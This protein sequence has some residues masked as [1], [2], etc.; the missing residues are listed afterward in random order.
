MRNIINKTEIVKIYTCESIICNC[1]GKEFKPED[2]YP[3]WANTVHG[4][5]IDFEY[6]SKHD[7]DNWSFDLCDDC[8][9]KITKRFK[10]P[11]KIHE[12]VA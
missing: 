10:I 7:M 11:V 1:C 3:C 8:I 12:G 4:F 6:G 5:S 9:E 2:D